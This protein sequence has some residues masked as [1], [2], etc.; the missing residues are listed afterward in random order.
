MK[1]II[2]QYGNY[3]KLPNEDKLIICQ[4][5]FDEY[6]DKQLT[7]SMWQENFAVSHDNYFDKNYANI[8][9]L[10]TQAEIVRQEIKRL[11]QNL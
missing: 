3:N 9:E 8:D 7:Q 10:K 2:E 11:K 6:F 5:W 1:S 4:I